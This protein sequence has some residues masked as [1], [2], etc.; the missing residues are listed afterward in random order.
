MTIMIKKIDVAILGASGVVGQKAIALLQDSPHFHVNEVVASDK[1]IG[2]KFQ[3]SVDWRETNCNLPIDVGNLILKNALDCKS[4]FIVSCLP[5]EM[6]TILEP[7]LAAAGKLVF[8]NASSFRMEKNVPLLVP[9]INEAHLK[10]L[11]DQRTLGKIIT[12]PNCSAVGVTLALAPLME[13]AAIDHVSVVTMQSASGA[14]LPGVSSLDL[15][16]NTIP[17]IENEFQKITEET[18]KILGL[19]NAPAN[20]AISTHV[21]RVP[22]HFGH[23]ATLHITFKESVNPQDAISQFQKWNQKFPDLF[24]LHDINGR[25]QPLRD[26][27]A[28]DMRA[29][30]GHIRQGDKPNI[31]GLIVLTHNLVRGAAGAVIANMTAYLKN[32]L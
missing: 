9:E 10:L 24:L 11:S 23:T 21:H 5:T 4:P 7:Q 31:L 16:G 8:S 28:N 2:Q 14:G 32:T 20:F 13:L 12:N 18:K 6:A 22:V 15:M 1:R 19:I 26:L 3:D 27:T 29:H 25:P 17:H 30:I